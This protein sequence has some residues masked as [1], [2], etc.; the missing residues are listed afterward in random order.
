MIFGAI[1]AGGKGSRMGI[2]KPKQFLTLG[3]KP[4]IVHTI[5]KFLLCDRIEQLYVGVHPD[6]V[7][8]AQD[9]INKYIETESEIVLVPGGGDRNSTIFNIVEEIEKRYG[10]SEEHIIVTHDSVRPFVTVRIINDNIDAALKYDACDTVVEAVDTIVVSEDGNVIAQIPNRKQMFQGQ[11]P[12]SFK[13]SLLKKLYNDLSE[14][15]KSILTDACKI[16]V[17]RDVPV[18][19]VKGEVSNLKI[20]TM[21]DLKIAKAM[22]REE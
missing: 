3:D 21:S 5:E 13:M 1:L 2:D 4:I 9:L 7:D 19:L 18:K 15:E 22:I 11:T 6:W 17:V 16:C 14:D 8:Y 12:Q 20:T 10:E